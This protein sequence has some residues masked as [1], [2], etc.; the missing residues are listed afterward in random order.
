MT[1]D[2]I[3]KHCDDY[4]TNM[5]K[6]ADIGNTGWWLE[7]YH[8]VLNG[9]RELKALE[10]QP[11]EIHCEFSDKNVAKAF[12]EDV[13]AVK[14][15]LD[16]QFIDAVSREAVLHLYK[17]FWRCFV[18]D[19]NADIFM[20]AIRDLPSVTPRTNLAEIPQDC[21]SRTELIQKLNGWD[22]KAHGIPNY[23][24]KVIREM[25]SVTPQIEPCEDAI[26]R[27]AVLKEL[28]SEPMCWT[29]SDAEIQEIN[30]YRWFKKIIETAKPV[31]PKYTDEEIDKAQ[32][33][34]QAYVDKMVELTVE[35]VKRPKGKWIK[36]QSG[37]EDFPES[38]VCSRCKGEN[39]HIDFNEHGEPI[40]KIFVMSKYC[41]NCGAYMSGG[42]EDEEKVSD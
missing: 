13:E 24:W 9:F 3:I 32:A 16:G 42:R 34:E 10:S 37:D 40:G 31:K 25:P 21:I 38:I 5:H 33:V 12:I 7:F 29:D 11:S 30:D 14:D 8:T 2:E 20:N 18:D 27:Q 19:A 36:I 39:S 1:I 4:I 6:Y 35:E 17:T 41:P 28:G 22:S 15:Q 26:S 23:A